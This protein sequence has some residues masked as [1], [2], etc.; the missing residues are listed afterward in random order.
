MMALS[1]SLYGSNYRIL[2]FK[3]M[4]F[5]CCHCFLHYLRYPISLTIRNNLNSFVKTIQVAQMFITDKLYL[6]NS[7]SCSHHLVPCFARTLPERLLLLYPQNSFTSLIRGCA[8][9]PFSTLFI[10]SRTSY[11]TGNCLLRRHPAFPGIS[12]ELK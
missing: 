2:Q 7:I 6:Q 5:S 3:Y 8:G 10:A 4:Q 11:G 12:C 9:T 1:S